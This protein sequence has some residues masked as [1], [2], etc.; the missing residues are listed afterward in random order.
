MP[1]HDW[2]D[3]RGWDSVNTLWINSLLI[4]LRDRLPAGYRAYLGSVPGLTIGTDLGRPDLM[5]RTWPTPPSDGETATATVATETGPAPDFHTVARNPDES[6]H[7]VLIALG[8]Q[9]VA[10]IELVSPRNKDRP[11]SREFYRNRYLGYLWSG[12]NLLLIDVHR[13]PIQFSFVQAIAVEMEC[14]LPTL[15]TPHAVSWSVGGPTPEGGRILDGWARPLTVG[16]PLPEVPLALSAEQN[17][18]IDLEQTY[19]RATWLAYVE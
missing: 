3:A 14:D 11:S 12:V 19:T 4:W 15:P 5:V 17:V 7:A 13:R 2:T 1:L 18:L 6:T 16:Q 10:A 9:L 8:S